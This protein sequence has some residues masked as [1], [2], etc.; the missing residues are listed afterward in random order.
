LQPLQPQLNLNNSTNAS[1]LLQHAVNSI[2][3]SALTLSNVP[4]LGLPHGANPN[5]AP[6]MVQAGLSPSALF[7]MFHS[8][9]MMQSYVLNQEIPIYHHHQQQQQQQ[10]QHHQQV[11]VHVQQQ[12]QQPHQHQHVH[13]LSHS[14]SHP[15]HHPHSLAQLHPHPHPHQHIHQHAMTIHAPQSQP[16]VASSSMTHHGNLSNMPPLNQHVLNPPVAQTQHGGHT[17]HTLADPPTNGQTSASANIGFSPSATNP[18]SSGSMDRSVHPPPFH[19]SI[20]V[21]G[22][23]WST[24]R[25]PRYVNPNG[26]ALIA[27]TRPKGIP[28]AFP[29]PPPAA[30]S[31]TSNNANGNATTAASSSSAPAAAAAATS[32]GASSA[33]TSG[34]SN[35]SNTNLPPPPPVLRP[36]TR[37]AP[38]VLDAT[39]FSAVFEVLRTPA[40][41]IRLDERVAAVNV[42]FTKTFGWT[43]EDVQ[44]NVIS[45]REL[46][47]DEDYP[48]A[49][50]CRLR[51][52]NRDC[53]CVEQSHKIVTAF[54]ESGANGT[55]SH[56]PE[57]R[58]IDSRCSST[59]VRQ[60][61]SRQP[62]A[63]VFE[64]LPW[65][66]IDRS[67]LSDN[68]FENMS[69][70]THGGPAKVVHP[71]THCVISARVLAYIEQMHQSTPEPVMQI[72]HV[73]NQKIMWANDAASRMFGRD[74]QMLSGMTLR[75][76]PAFGKSNLINFLIGDIAVN[77]P[78]RFRTKSDPLT[79][80]PRIV[81]QPVAVKTRDVKGG[82]LI[83]RPCPSQVRV[84]MQGAKVE[85]RGVGPD[86]PRC[87]Y[88]LFCECIAAN[89]DRLL[90]VPPLA[91]EE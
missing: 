2:P 77:L 84:Y 43:T 36:A 81:G 56:Q 21:D 58:Y 49:I 66:S 91:V 72:D 7:P 88:L 63:Y 55:Q 32:T 90:V 20:G 67:A 34:S 22:H 6:S 51:L 59:I 73:H 57:K 54:R 45:F 5:S 25:P 40:A 13:S 28:P 37:H 11:Q 29:Y 68:Y 16:L 46:L 23:Y 4:T 52:L 47:A 53:D 60:G 83:D 62:I 61:T 64:A 44:E 30:N 79:V 26:P 1:T 74:Q 89:G 71:P 14:L 9:G 65:S 69:V 76:V 38:V 33:A 50:D 87:V 42:A 19:M 86:E 8:P 70:L 82:R 10:Q 41:I 48:A 24:E 78:E 31:S 12:P 15:Q 85:V 39:M 80:S 3:P 18:T 17:L 27:S 35:T 75:N